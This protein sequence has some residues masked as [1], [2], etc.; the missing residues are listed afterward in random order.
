IQARY[1]S[2]RVS[3]IASLAYAVILPVPALM[4]NLWTLAAAILVFGA[5]NG[6]MDVSMNGH[7]ALVE[8][9]RGRP[10]MSSLH[11]AFSLGCLLGSV[12][13]SGI[14]ALGFGPV[15]TMGAASLFALLLVGA[16]APG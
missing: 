8:R 10:I 1:G 14:L 4:P 3:L 9:V 6:A 13:G 2:A 12:A 15:E 7:G 16:A 5:C 11:A